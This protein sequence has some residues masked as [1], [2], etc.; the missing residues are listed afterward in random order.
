MPNPPTKLTF[1][2]LFS[3]TLI[4]FPQNNALAFVGQPPVSYL[5]AHRKIQS[6]IGFLEKLGVKPA[7]KIAILSVNMPNWGLAYFATTFMG[8]VAVPLLPDFHPLEIEKFVEHSGAE[9]LFISKCLQYKLKGIEDKMPATI[10]FI[11]DFSIDRAKV[12]NVLYDADEVA[13]HTYD[14][15]ENDLAAIIYTSGTTGTPKGVM[16]SHRNISF[17]AIKAA[18][19]QPIDEQDRFLSILPLSH[20]YENTLGLILPMI[21]G[22][23]V[24]Y[25][26]KPPTPAVLIPAMQEVKPTL[27]LTVP[28]IIEKIYRNTILP[29]FTKKWIPRVLYQTA[30][31]HKL[32]NLLAGR[33]L[34]KTFGGKLKFFGIGGAKLDKTVEKFLIEARFPYAIG[35]GLTETSPLLAGSS[36]FQ[37]KLQS[38]GPALDGIELKIINQDAATGEGEILARGPNVML[39]YYKEPELTRTVLDDEGWFRTGDLGVLDKNQFLSIRGRLK[40]MIV[41]KTGENVYPEEIEGVINNFPY[42][43]ESL[44]VEQKG[45][46][47]ALVYF[48]TEEIGK[49]YEDLKTEIST[50]VDQKIEE[51]KVELE[52]Y[53]N[54]RVNKFSRVQTIIP[55]ADPFKKTATH[56]IKRF[57][58]TNCK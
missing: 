21:Y 37:T 45:K 49:K 52:I 54:K 31:V 44:V 1:P 55:Q 3:E 15:Q 57:L 47:V 4:N 48:N 23:C 14:V 58:Y 6:L 11:D 2:S 18:I 46:L 8:A 13:Q 36:P 30:F 53:V 38:T 33:K 5:Q 35:Y 19:I 17:T 51:L 56:K 24:Y 28:L 16:L 43:G 40:N 32:L 7:T 27:I 25:L 22:A 42:V 12:P 34:K 9:Y 50:Y 41:M 26:Q 20:T 10:I 39:G 29:K